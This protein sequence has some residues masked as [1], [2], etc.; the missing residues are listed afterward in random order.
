M[1]TSQGSRAMAH[2]IDSN[3]TLWSNVQALMHK[4]FGKIN[5]QGFAKKCGVGNG[6][7]QRIQGQSTSVG[8][9][10]LDKIA[11]AHELAAWQLL[12][13]GFDPENPPTLQPVSKRERE[14]YEKLLNAAKEIARDAT[15]P[16]YK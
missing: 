1:D 3:A 13:P 14:L 4:D 6:T 10:V 7:V 8:L 11:E 9:E 15:P 12:V 5:L 16:P 2:Q